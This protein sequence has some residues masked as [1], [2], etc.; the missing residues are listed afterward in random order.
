M[1]KHALLSPSGAHRWLNCSL[2]PRLEAEL[3]DRPSE[4][5]K[6]GTLAHSVCEITAKKYFKKV[7]AA[8]Y[9]KGHQAAENK[10]VVGR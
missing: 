9:N 5:A 6:E 7:K 4:Y 1:S 2:A 10:L 3:P 8:E